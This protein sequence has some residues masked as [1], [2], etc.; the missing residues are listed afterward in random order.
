MSRYNYCDT[1]DRT[2]FKKDAQTAK[3]LIIVE[4]ACDRLNDLESQLEEARE[5]KEELVRI[6]TINKIGALSDK[7]VVLGLREYFKEQLK[8]KGDD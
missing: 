7:E 3:E 6:L 5:F 4:D 8:E 2:Y 1:T